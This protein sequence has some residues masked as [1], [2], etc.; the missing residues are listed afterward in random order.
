MIRRSEMDRALRLV[1]RSGVHRTLEA[2]VRPAEA[3]GRPRQLSMDVFLAGIIVTASSGRRLALTEVH[4]TLTRELARSARVQL[5]TCWSGQAGEECNLSVRQVRYLLEAIEKKLAYTDGRAP[6]LSEADKEHRAAALQNIADA[7]L[8]ATVP[9]HLPPADRFALDSTVI[10]SYGR[11]RRRCKTTDPVV[12]EELDLAE[13]AG[14]VGDDG[15]AAD[16]DARWC[17]RTRTYDNKT[18]IVFGYDAFAITRINAPQDSSSDSPKLIE[19]LVVAP[20]GRDVTAPALGMLDRLAQ[21][22]RVV[23]E[24]VADRAWSYKLPE[25]WAYELR[26]RNIEQVLDLHPNDHGARDHEGMRII[27]GVPHCPSMPDELVDIRRPARL[28]AGEKPGPG[29]SLDKL[30][31]WKQASD[32]LEE[33]QAKIEERQTYA[34]RRVA[35]PDAK[36]RERY[37]CPAQAGKIKCDL[38]PLSQLFPEDLAT[39]AEPPAPDTAP[40]CCTQRTVTIP[41]T[42]T[43]KVRQRLYWGSPEWISA[44]NRRVRIEG[45]F[46]NLK[47]PKTENIRRGWTYVMG[48]IKT[49]LMLVCATVAGNLRLLRKWAERTGDTA[50]ELTR[51]DPPLVGFEEIDPDAGAAGVLGPPLTD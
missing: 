8:A 49:T 46:G 17:Y 21:D 26:A 51:P 3:G 28:S 15:K 39:V 29:A 9:A 37:E 13:L 50:D 11:G 6:D 18:S 10:E 33:F 5:G 14:Y 31:S 44:F 19:R 42:V 48:L 27:A 4:K 45:S 1:Q 35:G 43:P 40:K 36:G 12:K 32:E 20:G 34:F 16:P 22:E 2:L 7:L 41:G 25:A 38:C 30:R 23:R 47:S 24:V